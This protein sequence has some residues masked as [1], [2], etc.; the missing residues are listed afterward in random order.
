M[1]AVREGFFTDVKGPPSIWAFHVLAGFLG[2][3][4]TD[5]DHFTTFVEIGLLASAKCGVFTRSGCVA[6]PT[7]RN[8]EF[9]F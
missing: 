4:V 6:T 3:A 5:D 9:S 1:Q 2:N 7:T 8:P